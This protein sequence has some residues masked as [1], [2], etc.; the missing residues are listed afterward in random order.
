MRKAHPSSMGLRSFLTVAKTLQSKGGTLMLCG[1][2]GMVKE[3]FDMTHLTP[4]FPLF[5]SPEA[6]LRTL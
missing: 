4:L 2:T 1:M 6:A 5:E 3:V